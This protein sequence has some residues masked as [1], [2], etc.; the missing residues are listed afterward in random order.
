MA[1]SWPSQSWQW[2]STCRNNPE[3]RNNFPMGVISSFHLKLPPLPLRRGL[4]RGVFPHVLI[5]THRDRQ[6][7]AYQPERDAVLR[8]HGR[9]PQASLLLS[10]DILA[11]SLLEPCGFPAASPGRTRVHRAVALTPHRSP[12]V[13]YPWLPHGLPAGVPARA[14]GVP[15]GVCAALS[16]G[17]LSGATLWWHCFTRFLPLRRHDGMLALL[18]MNPIINRHSTIMESSARADDII[19]TIQLHTAPTPLWLS[20][21]SPVLFWQLPPSCNYPSTPSSSH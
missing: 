21:T 11:A 6:R 16:V 15:C 5:L 2:C 3:P 12:L 20:D 13:S 8:P 18:S 7:R 9:G 19:H 17:R 14:L 10:R 1:S 4:H